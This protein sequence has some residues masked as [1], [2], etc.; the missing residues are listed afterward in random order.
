MYESRKGRLRIEQ[1]KEEKYARSIKLDIRAK[2]QNLKYENILNNRNQVIQLI[3]H[4]F[5][6]EIFPVK[7]TDTYLIVSNK[8]III[9][10]RIDPVF[11]DN[12]R[13]IDP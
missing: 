1:I 12:I 9:A 10:E 8:Y 11:I 13:T 6:Q 5:F 2:N 3:F 7:I 4:N